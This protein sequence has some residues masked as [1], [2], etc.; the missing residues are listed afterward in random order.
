MTR[1]IRF[2]EIPVTVEYDPELDCKCEA[3]SSAD[4]T[5]GEFSLHFRKVCTNH[6]A[7]ECWHLFLRIMYWMDDVQNFDFF[8]LGSEIYAWNFGFLADKVDT[9]LKEMISEYDKKGKD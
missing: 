4:L 6:I 7:H 9:A 3:Y 8:N 2:M 1:K 5:K